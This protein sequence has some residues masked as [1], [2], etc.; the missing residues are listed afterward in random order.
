MYNNSPI[1]VDLGARLDAGS[2]L[3]LSK[4][5]PRRRVK[6]EP[7]LPSRLP[8]TRF[9]QREG[10]KSA[11]KSLLRQ[12]VR[13]P[14]PPQSL[15]NDEPTSPRPESLRERSPSVS[16]SKSEIAPSSTTTNG[17][18]LAGKG[19][20]SKQS[21][22]KDP[23][24]FEI[25]RAIERKD[26]M[27]IMEIRDRAFHLL[28]KKSGD[29]TPLV[30]AMRIGESHRD[31]TILILGALSRWVNHLEDSDMA[32]KKTK[33]LLKALRVNL[34]LAI[35]YGLQ[36]SQSDL[37]A[38]FMQTLIM[39]EGE[40][41]VSGQASNT[42]LALRAGTAGKPV[43]TAEQ[44]VRHFA[45]KELGKADLIAA[46]EDY[47]ANAT[48]D[49]LVMGAWSCVLDVVSA[50]PIPTYYFARDD[51]VF[52]AFQDRVYKYKSEINRTVSKRLKW[53]IR[54]LETVLEGRSTTFRNKIELLAGELDEGPGI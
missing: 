19:K 33:P 53:Q 7:C 21:S 24:P 4:P 27:F 41:W 36:R 51:R 31:V 17:W 37:I 12:L 43:H 9:L 20:S 45:T 11:P 18:L 48:A 40:K 10:E 6:S 26:V 30:H 13:I 35:D 23:Q 44:A 46:L 49:L 38:S 52:K 5:E 15:L 50:E 25:F 47:V 1:V 54:V 14:S 16:S 39:S 8:S 34:K 29:A 28:L 22:W 42:A 3:N 2:S 32:D